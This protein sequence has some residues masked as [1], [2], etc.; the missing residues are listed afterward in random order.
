MID[1]D[2]L[3]PLLLFFNPASLIAIL[4]LRTTKEKEEEGGVRM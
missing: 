1:G 3:P 4:A 2:G